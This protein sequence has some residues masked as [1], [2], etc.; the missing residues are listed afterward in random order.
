MLDLE[1]E[2][3]KSILVTRDHQIVHA[4]TLEAMNG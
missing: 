4:G 1:D 2:I 3:C